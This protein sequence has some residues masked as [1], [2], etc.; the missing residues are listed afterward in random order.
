MNRSTRATIRYL[1][2]KA[3][4]DVVVLLPGVIGRHQML[5]AI[6]DPLHR[7]PEAHG[8]PGDHEVLGVELA[9][10]AEAASHFELHEVD[11]VFGVAEEVGQDAPVEV[12][13]LGHT[14][15][16][17][18][19]GAGVEGGGEAAC[20]QRHAGVALDGEA[21]PHAVP[22]AGHR[23]RG[24]AFGRLQPV[25]EVP[26]DRRVEHGRA[27][28]EGAPYVGEHL[29]RLVVDRD[30]VEGVLGQVAALGDHDG[31]RVPTYRTIS[32]ASGRCRQST[33]PMR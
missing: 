13:D 28:R 32:R 22:G 29:Q 31:H 15:K 10:D 8:R 5:P 9:A 16:P 19:A 17:Q 24:I 25:H 11:E 33:D 3:N 18:H 4:L 30:K 14:P 23:L 2:V 21:F 26:A 12:R 6:L 27:R 20:L 7:P 1:A